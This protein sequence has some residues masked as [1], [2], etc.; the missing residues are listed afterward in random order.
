M[1]PW[2]DDVRRW[3]TSSY[4][5]GAENNCVEVA[6]PLNAVRDSKNP[7]GPVLE[8]SAEAVGAFLA[9]VKSGRFDA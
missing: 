8:W 9:G 4:T 6:G 5:G 7:G 3:R 1:I 2:S